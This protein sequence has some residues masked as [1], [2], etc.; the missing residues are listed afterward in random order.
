MADVLF[1]RS[2]EPAVETPRTRDF[3]DQKWSARRTLAFVVSA[4]LLLWFLILSPFF[5]LR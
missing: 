2:V 1:E 5:L 4:S 3:G